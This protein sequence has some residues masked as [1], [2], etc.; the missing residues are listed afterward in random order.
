MTFVSFSRDTNWVALRPTA[1]VIFVTPAVSSAAISLIYCFTTLLL[2]APASPLSD[3]TTIKRR[4]FTTRVVKSGCCFVTPW[5]ARYVSS[6]LAA[7]AYGAEAFVDSC[8]RR[9][10]LAATICIAFVICLV[11]FTERIRD[12]NAWVDAIDY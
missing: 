7:S 1:I 3:A 9:I 11:F 5:L 12:F 2:Y 4:V 6:S 10:L 8:A